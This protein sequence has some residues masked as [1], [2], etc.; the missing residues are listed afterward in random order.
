[1]RFEPVSRLN[2]SEPDV[3]FKGPQIQCLADELRPIINGDDFWQSSGQGHTFKHSGNPLAGQRMVCFEHRAFTAEVVY[4]GQNPKASAVVE[5]VR[6]KVHG[7]VL[8]DPFWFVHDHPEMADTLS[9]L[10]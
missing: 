2:K 4:Y 10:L 3:V 6:Y 1:M 9:A 7:P 8:V 5:T